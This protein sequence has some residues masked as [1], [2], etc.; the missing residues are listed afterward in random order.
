[1]E[2]APHNGMDAVAPYENIA[3]LRRQGGAVR[4]DETCGDGIF[5]LLNSDAAMTG[6]EILRPDPRPHGIE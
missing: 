6:R 4:A 3:P 5:I 2:L 1:M